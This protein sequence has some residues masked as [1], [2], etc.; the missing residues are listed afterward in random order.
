MNNFIDTSGDIDP[1]CG[2]GDGCFGVDAEMPFYLYLVMALRV[3]A[4]L[5]LIWTTV[6]LLRKKVPP[7]QRRLELKWIVGLLIFIPLGILWPLGID[8]L[9]LLGLSSY[10]FW[11]KR[12]KGTLTILLVFLVPLTLVAT[13]G[14]M[15]MNILGFERWHYENV[16]K[17]SFLD[18]VHPNSTYGNSNGGDSDDGNLAYFPSAEQGPTIEELNELVF[19]KLDSEWQWVETHEG[20]SYTNYSYQHLSE[21]LALQITIDEDS[22]YNVHYYFSYPA[23]ESILYQLK[24]YKIDTGDKPGDCIKLFYIFQEHYGPSDECK[25]SIL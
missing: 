8:M 15:I 22:S 14:I 3:V 24:K 12:K 7:E 10:Y 20:S 5:F 21:D 4:L 11:K 19:N 25:Y 23:E 18:Y 6:K 2:G 17:E 16:A 1:V 9:W 13:S